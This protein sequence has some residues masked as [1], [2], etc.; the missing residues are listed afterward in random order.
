MKLA[1][2]AVL[3]SRLPAREVVLITDFQRIGWERGEDLRLPPGTELV[4]G[5]SLEREGRRAPSNLAVAGLMLDRTLED[6]RERVVAQARVTRRGGEGPATASLALELGG[7]EIGR[8]EIELA[9]EASTLVAFD[10]F[11]LPAGTSRGRVVLTG[12]SLAT[13]NEFFFVLSRAQALPVILIDDGR[14]AGGPSGFFVEQALRLGQQPV[15]DLRRRAASRSAAS[16]LAQAAVV[17]VSDV[18]LDGE[19]V[20]RLQSFVSAGG[21]LIVALGSRSDGTHAALAAAGLVPGPAGNAVGGA[22][23][24]D[25][26]HRLGRARRTPVSSR[27]P[28]RAA[29]TSGPRASSAI[30][31][32]ETGDEDRVLA[33][34]DDGDAALVERTVGSGRVLVWTSTFDT[35]WNDFALQ[36]VFLPFM[37]QI[38]K[39]LAGFR[40][41]ATSQT[42]GEVV[43]LHSLPELGVGGQGDAELAATAPSGRSVAVDRRPRA[44][45]AGL[46]HA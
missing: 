10:P 6:D 45:R 32:C 18:A 44:R 41:P 3:D 11:S 13:D 39:S 30:A 33:R 46:L 15:I 37:H 21:G 43:D 24:A 36:P 42:V 28:D 8:R 38:T 9:P 31:S 5:R 34:F 20:R 17:V 14:G 19:A 22:G 35:Y 7:R 12:D 27:S 1:R 29:A 16:D 2:K 26:A 4:V 40:P 25:R 23:R